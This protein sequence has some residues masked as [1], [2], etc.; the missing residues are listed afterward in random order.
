MKIGS[1]SGEFY[2][3]EDSVGFDYSKVGDGVYKIVLR[4]ELE[5]GEY[6]LTASK[7]E[8]IVL[9]N[10]GVNGTSN[11]NSNSNSNTLVKN[12]QKRL[13]ELGYKP[14]PKDGIFGK[15]VRVALINFQQ[16]H[17][18]PTTGQLDSRTI[19]ELKI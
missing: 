18:I 3:Y 10:F 9:Y 8:K 2:P 7:G 1:N 15:R 4:E 19:K 5:P 12:A 16:D 11:R 6:V 13:V 14:G 17:D